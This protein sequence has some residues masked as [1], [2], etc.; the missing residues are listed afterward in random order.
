MYTYLLRLSLLVIIQLNLGRDLIKHNWSISIN[1]SKYIRQI[2]FFYRVLSVMI[3]I[4]IF[5]CHNP[6]CAR[7]YS[8][9]VNNIATTVVGNLLGKF[10][11]LTKKNFIQVVPKKRG[12]ILLRI[13]MSWILTHIK[14][15][16]VFRFEINLTFCLSIKIRRRIRVNPIFFL[17]GTSPSRFGTGSNH[18]N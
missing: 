1:R 7:I 18:L 11:V 5:R 6:R 9:Q 13:H 4:C 10:Y 17:R 12:I 8:R 2:H 14:L 15:E 3:K 16:L